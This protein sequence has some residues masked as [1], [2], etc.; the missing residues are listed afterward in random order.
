MQLSSKLS[1][2]KNQKNRELLSNRDIAACRPHAF[3]MYSQVC[4]IP[5][6][7]PYSQD[8]RPNS[9]ER[10]DH[11]HSLPACSLSIVYKVRRE[12]LRTEFLSL[13]QS[14]AQEART[15]DLDPWYHW[16]L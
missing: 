2:N 1:I 16:Q 12:K 6:L 15:C 10:A 5:V 13:V 8:G 11:A 7:C 14:S 4:A 9:G 3:L